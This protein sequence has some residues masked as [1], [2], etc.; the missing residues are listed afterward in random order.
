M[1]DLAATG[2]A[3]SGRDAFEES[4]L[5]P[6]DMD[7]VQIYDAF[8]INPIVILEDLGFCGKGSGGR[9]FTEGRT[10]PGGD[11][12]LN[13]SGG[14]LSFTHPGMFGMFTLLEA[15][16]Q[17]RGECGARQVE[18][19]RRALAHGVGGTMSS[20]CTVVLETE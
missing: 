14:G 13:T 12:P 9:L 2:A 3:R 7:V 18:G 10:A 1:P 15:V 5:G 20:H 8:T 4:G 19:A 16:H 11:L 6:E 17:L